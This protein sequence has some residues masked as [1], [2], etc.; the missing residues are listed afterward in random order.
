MNEEELRAIL[1]DVRLGRVSRRWFIERM[2][3]LGLAGPLVGEMLAAAGTAA[4]AAP[5]T[6]TP[7]RRG[8]GGPLKV[9]MWQAPTLL[10]PRLAVGTKDWDAARI[11]YEPLA[12]YD[13]DG[14][15]VPVL[16]EEIPTIA[17]GQLARDARAVTW[18][19][20]RGVRWHDGKPFTADDVVFNWQYAMDP[21]TGSPGLVG[22]QAI[23]R[24]DAVD[25]YTVRLT[26]KA[27][28][29]FWM[30]AFCGNST[31]IPRHVFEPYRGSASREA[32]ANMRPVG[33]GPYRC[34]DFKP[35]DMIKAEINAD[36]HVPNRPFFD[37][38]EVKGGGDAV[39]AARAVL[40]TGAYDYAPY[41]GGVDDSILARLE[42]SGRGKVDF[43][44]GGDILH[45][46]V[47]QTDPWTDVDGERSS[48][49]TQ[50]P[51]L[52]DPA[53]KAALSLLIDRTTIQ[54][55]VLGRTAIPTINWL[56]APAAFA[57]T[58]RQ[59]QFD[60]D[61]ANQILETGGWRRGPDG[62]RQRNGIR[63]KVVFQT[64]IVALAQKIQ[65]IVKQ[66]VGKAG[67][68]VELKA[69]TPAVFAGSDPSNRDTYT[70]F[71]ADLQLIQYFQSAPDP[72]RFMSLFIS[73]EVPSKENKYQRFNAPRW[74]SR[75]YDELFAAARI[76]VDP[77]K[78]ASLFIR[79]NDLLIQ[80]GAV[81]P[82]ARRATI[83]A[84]AVTIKGADHS[85]WD[86]AFWRL[87]YWYREA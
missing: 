5:A 73:D 65:A 45:I 75:V 77:V 26:F 79:L 61:K 85:A 53:V 31:I 81:L 49:K 27:P 84:R 67:F 11:F 13:A 51:F 87:A 2:L 48:A 86:R 14:T 52:L 82:I 55:E 34:V 24:A 1:D 72:E 8:G 57:P 17:N 16:A 50:H 56:N 64:A 43:A 39:S 30:A 33:T 68:E 38:V 32:P 7:T 19:L 6:F 74:R 3:G 25:A 63:L 40:Q 71:N 23:E 83:N 28:T 60:I 70:H 69:V 4:A 12:S 9:L 22:L 10:N 58:P 44:F 76:E 41:M 35:G 54:Q 20:K 29:P 21:A 15:L 78:R 80:G 62:I 37:A 18:R 46:Q 36:Y 66:A 59:G 47:N 42:A